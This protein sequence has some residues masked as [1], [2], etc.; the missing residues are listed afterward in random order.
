MAEDHTRTVRIKRQS[1]VAQDD[2]GRNVWVGRVDE[3]AELELISTTALQKILNSGDGKSQVEIRRLAASGKEGVLARDTATGRYEIVDNDEL[4]SIAE[5]GKVP[6]PAHA[7]GV[8]MAAPLS[9]DALRKAEELSLVST[10]VLRKVVG[11]DGKAEFVNPAADGR[12]ARESTS[13]RPGKD[14]FGGFDP[15]NKN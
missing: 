4:K 12:K 13:D 7:G 11:A 1:R 8:N 14:D 3:D 5:T 6:E 2:R 15:Y 9:E 10:M